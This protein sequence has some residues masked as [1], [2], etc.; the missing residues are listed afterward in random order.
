M[1]HK[2]PHLEHKPTPVTPTLQSG[3][4][5]QPRPTNGQLG[6]TPLPFEESPALQNAGQFIIG[7]KVGKLATYPTPR[8]GFPSLHGM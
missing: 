1:R 5:A 7:A 6:D 8:R 2:L 3:E 4:E